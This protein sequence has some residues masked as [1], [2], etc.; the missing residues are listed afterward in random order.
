MA[1]VQPG[2]P[3]GKRLSGALSVGGSGARGGAD[4]ALS[5]ISLEVALSPARRKG[6]LDGRIAGSGG[7]L[8]TDSGGQRIQGHGE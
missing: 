4:A 3:P 8:Q 5:I 7:G 6:S 2:G 1:G